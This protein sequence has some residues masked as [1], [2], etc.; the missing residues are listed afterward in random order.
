MPLGK[1]IKTPNEVKRYSIDYSNWLDT[2]EYLSAVSFTVTPTATVPLAA[3]ASSLGSSATSMTYSVSG[4]DD[5]GTYEIV[6][7]VTTT[8]GQVKEDAVLY[9][10]RSI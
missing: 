10:V 3:T 5:G 4:G 2:G 6:V 9:V 1:F 8:Q 7:K